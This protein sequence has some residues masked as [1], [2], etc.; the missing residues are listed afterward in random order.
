VFVNKIDRLGAGDERVLAAIR[1]RLTPA[2][3]PMGAARS[4]GTR[5]ARFVRDPDFVGRAAEMLAERD[6]GM[7]EA[8]VADDLDDA[9]VRR[10]LAEQ[11][12]RALVYPV[13][14]GSA[15]TGAGVDDLRAG[16]PELLPLS[17]GDAEGPLSGAVFKIERGADGEKIAYVRL[18]SGTLRVRDRLR[19]DKV[20][21]IAVYESGRAAQGPSISAGEVGKLWGLAGVRVGDR[22]GDAGRA[23]RAHHFAPPTLEAV[24]S[25][26]R[27]DDGPR[28][29]VA[30]AQLAEQDP[31]I[32]VRQDDER[33]EISVSLYGEVQKEV[34]EATLADDYGLDVEFREATPL[35][36]ERPVD[37]G[38]AVELLHA[39]SNPYS[40]TIGL[41]VV[42]TPPGSGVEFELRVGA[43][44]IPLYVYKTR[45]K[46]AE[47]MDAYVRDALR[48]G[49]AG[50]EVTDCVVALT[51]CAYAVAD[52]PP[53][54]RGPTST[55]ADFRKLTPLVLAQALER[56]GTTVCEPTVRAR[57]EIPSDAIGAV[58]PAIGRLGGAVEASSTAGGLAVVETILSAVRVRDL[59]RRLPSLTGGEGVLE[60]SF[61]GYQPVSGE[62]PTRRTR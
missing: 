30:L 10:E 37:I 12:K 45:E 25:P 53:S 49:L 29:R 60:S 59:Q 40:A 15:I 52:G 22:I 14:F 24:V 47:H 43:D 31:L 34:I 23:Q 46:F 27:H 39:E 35:Y 36:V 9:R 18:F 20:T 32:D 56:A 2:V 54:R 57:I 61:A 55:A 17:S 51:T 6:E 21:S 4:L 3:V 16:V 26:R 1:E 44:S 8:L 7:L 62:R 19:E 33:G 50:W 5:A 13:F 11:T 58:V 41:T 48:E 28:L 42:P 38:E